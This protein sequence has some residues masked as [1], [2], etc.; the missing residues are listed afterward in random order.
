MI[1]LHDIRYVRLGT[2]NLE[3]AQ[4]YATEILGLEVIR[5]METSIYFRSDER[6]HTLCYFRGDPGDHTAGFEVTTQEE[7]TAAADTLANNGFRVYA[8]TS[9]DCG[10]RYVQQYI[11][12]I[13][14][15][16]NSIDLVLRPHNSGQRYFP[17]RDAGI[18]GFSHIGLRT[19]DAQRDEKFWTQLAS[20]RVSDRLGEAALLRIDGVHHKIA[21]FPS[22][23]AGIQ[24]VNHQVESVDDVMRAYYFLREKGIKIMFGPGRHATSGAVFLYFMGPDRMVYEYSTGVRI[25]TEEED[26]THHPRQFSPHDPK[27]LCLWGSKPEMA[28]FQ[29]DNLAAA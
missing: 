15:S 24:H 26:A 7:L 12:F 2:E 5:K 28:E 20:A 17:S 22:T 25:F 19:T 27:A 14:P 11:N 10:E 16:G 9:Q 3:E 18:T 13:D 6:D 29:S 1:N 23:Y 4:R 8:G 21:L